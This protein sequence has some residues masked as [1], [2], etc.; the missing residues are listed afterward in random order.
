M[1]RTEVVNIARQYAEAIEEKH[2]FEQLINGYAVGI[3]ADSP[4]D[5]QPH[6]A[7]SFS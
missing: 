7:T 6:R 5:R 1:D 2:H 3:D 4:E